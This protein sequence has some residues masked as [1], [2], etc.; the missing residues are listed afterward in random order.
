MLYILNVAATMLILPLIAIAYEM[1]LGHANLVVLAGKWFVFWGVGVR[2]LLAGL[3]QQFRPELTSRGILGIDDPKA[4]ILAR[5][6]GGANIAAGTIGL[7]SLAFPSFVLPI[8][9]W[10]A[11]FYAFA[12]VEHVKEEHRTSDSTIALVS[13]LFMAIVLGAFAAISLSK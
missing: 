1:Q 10:G 12:A 9:I 13:D 8:A 11:I 7:L 6:L 3:R 2:L 4:N 5:E